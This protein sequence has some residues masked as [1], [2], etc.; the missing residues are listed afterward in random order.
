VLATFGV[1]RDATQFDSSIYSGSESLVKQGEGTLVLSAAN[2]HSG[3][4]VV[5]QGT[6]VVRNPAALGSGVVEVRSGAKLVLDGGGST[7]FEVSN[8]VLQPGGMIDV[9]TS[10]LSIQSG[11]TQASLVAAIDEAQGADGSW[12]GQSGIG[13]SVVK[14]MVASGTTRTLGWVGWVTNNDSSCIVG[15]AAPGDT[16][17][18]GQ[19]DIIDVANM[20]DGYSS[21]PE[22][23]AT[24]GVG[25]FN[26]D[27]TADV[28]DI[29]TYVQVGLYDTGSYLPED[30]PAAP[31]NLNVTA[32]STS[33]VS[34]AWETADSPRGFEIEQSSDGVSGWRAA[35]D[36]Y[37]L[38]TI[39]SASGTTTSVTIGG[40]SAGQSAFFRVRSYNDSPSW[41]WDDRYRSADTPAASGTTL[42]SPSSVF[43][44]GFSPVTD[45]NWIITVNGD[46]SV[47]ASIFFNFQNVQ[48]Q[49]GR[50][51][52]VRQVK[53]TRTIQ[54]PDSVS[55]VSATATLEW[56]VRDRLRLNGIERVRASGYDP[57]SPTRAMTFDL[58][59][60]DGD[61]WG[62]Y[63]FLTVNG[64]P[65]DP[66]PTP[67][68]GPNPGSWPGT[69]PRPQ[70]DPGNTGVPCNSGCPINNDRTSNNVNLP[71]GLLSHRDGTTLAS[72]AAG[73]GS[74][75]SLEWTN[76]AAAN[77]NQPFGN[78]WIAPGLPQ[79]Q[80]L[81]SDTAGPTWLAIPFSGSDT[82][83]FVR[84]AAN[85]SVYTPAFGGGSSDS[86]AKVGSKFEFR[87]VTGDTL[88]FNDFSS[89]TAGARGQFVEQSDAFGNRLA[90]TPAADGAM[91]KLESFSAGRT[92][93]TESQAYTVIPATQP[94]AGKVSQVDVRRAD[95]TTVRSTQYAYYTTGSSFGAAGDLKSITVLDGT[96]RLIDVKSYRYAVTT[97]AGNV[98]SRLQGVFDGDGWRRLTQAGL[99]IE[100]ASNGLV[101][102]YARDWYAFDGLGRVG[103][104]DIQGAGCSACTAGIGTYTYT[105]ENNPYSIDRGFNDWQT[106]TTETRPDGTQSITYSNLSGQTM[107]AVIR[108]SDAGVTKQYGTY[109]R[110]DAR[111]L[112]IWRASPE[113]VVLPSNLADIEPYRDLVNQSNGNCQYISDSSGMIEVT[114]YFQS[115]TATATVAN[116]ADRFVSST[117][118]MRGEKGTPITQ[119]AFTY[120]V[121]SAGVRTATTVAARTTYPTATTG[122]GQTTRYLYTWVP[123]TTQLNSMTEYL[124]VVTAEQNG[125][126]GASTEVTRSYDAAGR[127]IWS[128]DADGYLNYTSYDPETGA[129]KTSIKDVSTSRTGDFQNLPTGWAT[130]AGGGLHLVSTFDVDRLGRTIKA[131]DPAGNVTYTVYDDVNHST[132]TYVGW[133]A[134]TLT[135][136]GPIQVSRRDLSGT[137]TESLTYSAT[138]AVDAQGRP[139]GTEPITNLQWLTRSLMNAAGQVIA[140]DRYTNLIGLAYS[141]A[142]T[143]SGMATL[144]FEGVNY[145][146][147]RYAYNNQGQVDRVQNP[148]GTITISAYDGLARLT[149]TW[150]GT[151]DSTTNGFK[152][153]PSNASSSSNM[154]KVRAYEYDNGHVGNGNLTAA[155]EFPGGTDSPRVTQNS[156]DWRNRPVAT[157]TAAS[158][159]LATED[160]SVN[161]PLSVADYD[162]LGRVT[163]RSIYDGDG[164]ALGDT[165][166]DGVP[167]KPA[168]ALLRRS[169]VSVYDSQDRVYRTQE[170]FIDQTTGAVGAQSLTTNL[171]YDRRGNVAAVYAPNTPVSQSRYDG[172]GRLTGSFTLGNAPSATWASATS[173]AASLIL[174][175]IEYTYDAA[176]NVILTTDRERFHDASTTAFGGLGTP[177]TGIIARVSYAASYFDAANRLSAT[178]NVGTAG[179]IAY[180]RPATALAR[181]NTALVTSYTYDAAGRVQNVIDPKGIVARTLYDALGRTTTTIA[182]FTDGA[183]GSQTDVTTRFTFDAAGRL[184]SRTAVQPAGTPS[185]VTGYV[186]GI[187]PATGSTIASNDI[188]A[189]T[190]YPD[191][192]TG[193]ASTSERDTYTSNAL[194]ERTSLTDRA[195]TTHRYAYNVA[196]RLTT[197]TVT[198]AGSGVDAAI[199]RIRRVYDPLGRILKATSVKTATGEGN[200]S[201]Q[202]VLGYNGFGQAGTEWQEH[203]GV[204]GV[205]TP[206]VIYAYSQGSGGNHSR[207][208]QV[209]YPSGYQ[210]NYAYSGI[211]SAV[212]RPTSLSG[213]RANS[214]ASATFEAFKYLGAGTVVERS[215]PEVNVTLSMLNLSG[216]TAG[217]AGDKYTGLD[218]FGRVVDQRWTQGT[219]ATSPVVDRLTYTYDRNSN[220]LTRS[221]ALAAAFSETYGYDALNQLQSF[222]RGPESLPTTTQQWQPDALGN[223]LSVTTNRITQSSTPNAQ[224]EL[225]QVGSASPRYSSTGNLTTDAQGRTLVYDAWN[226][227]VSVKNSVGTEVARY[228]YDGLNRRITERVGTVA[229]PSAA[230]A[231]VRDLYY[232]QDWQV[233]EE[234]V[235]TSTGTIPT[236][237]DTRFIWSPVYVDAMIARDRNADGNAATGTGG[238]EQR[239]YA[240]QDANWNTTAIV[241]ATGVS[242]VAAG[243]VI[244]RFI[245]MPYGES[246]TLTATWGTPAAGST[247]ATP[248]SHLFQGLKVTDVTGLAYVRHRDYSP[249][250][251][252]FIELDPI[253]FAAG[254]NNWYRFVGN[255]PTGRTDP[256]GLCEID[257]Q[258]MGIPVT[259][260]LPIP[261]APKPVSPALDIPLPGKWSS[262]SINTIAGGSQSENFVIV[263]REAKQFIN[264]TLID[265]AVTAATAG[266][267]FGHVSKCGP[268]NRLGS[269]RRAGDNIWESAGGLRYAGVDRDGL[270]RVQHV[271]RHAETAGPTFTVFN[272]GRNNILA[273][274]DEAWRMRG[275]P[276]VN[277]PG[278]FVV[279]M[280]R[281]V[282]TAGENAVKIIVR[283]GTNE[284]ITAYP[285]FVP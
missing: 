96:G 13:S 71:T 157:K 219:A 278:A 126:A 23:A 104:H 211:D 92:V 128:R 79:L 85:S 217:D 245:Y 144:G 76:S 116:G 81:A 177:T 138:P 225:T 265:T 19:V 30:P 145:L 218:R 189:E 43:P 276:L 108:T 149:G 33:D 91:T 117:A 37:N 282:G 267:P 3:G 66:N 166:G 233:L 45:N 73:I 28:L 44:A 60:I 168:A 195:G 186:Y 95:N 183:A 64:S 244:N 188:L 40:F 254:D 129:V 182:N 198:A 107:L 165:N 51:D 193:V 152:W 62:G 214:T 115:T 32:L 161:R 269:L 155:T 63:V 109:T 172:A 255:S 268:A 31:T 279:R 232:S 124:P 181:S 80:Q 162:N 151:N 235:R 1:A 5:E 230:S 143:S 237:A 207:L 136:T 194:G 93:A 158:S 140:V 89:A 280:G 146:R 228:E 16:N 275:S 174:E 102:P 127:E 22:A 121:Q 248:W 118:V 57:I 133:I 94:N 69:G 247:P 135:P 196:G 26:R 210:V 100:T 74:D 111:G 160:S 180:V 212:S 263:K 21:Y 99:N 284:I 84:S 167:D 10:Q 75:A 119:E 11:F 243:N 216:T 27:G 202:V 97:V 120:Y 150:V 201:N 277:D 220:R 270:N 242:G 184:D 112:P 205:G 238:L 222:A 256:S 49:P 59:D 252:R 273:L 8:L 39:S 274:V 271:L 148:A 35:T 65:S 226:R 208:T 9:G 246:N 56:G 88:T 61:S 178:A 190:R 250:L 7:R 34:L 48:G 110:Y 153:T 87:T 179:G 4:T 223:W 259:T 229:F 139:T 54:I 137:Y 131:T 199:L 25:D 134:S 147:T 53:E 101:K 261:P 240:L 114:S 281:T 47:S 103:Q 6:L 251:G 187:S 224:N 221:N 141:T 67:D 98:V 163:G 283:P 257:D 159:S 83:V 264:D 55:L 260:W 78:G 12:N 266:V 113:A 209:T 203:A 90:A 77:G 204:A 258:F 123:G 164:V 52:S 130:P 86:I 132:R 46:S 50:G 38:Q 236:T 234:R 272:V 14:A 285:V 36:A 253:G 241:A 249:T 200:V 239:V 192:V 176:S 20:S 105:Y 170:L 171:F 173:L 262:G 2:T 175:Q 18:D 154:V 122:G 197:D 17:L 68:P 82:R 15:F 58:I 106:K 215:R 156:Y 24:W 191:P 185:Q 29:A 125:P 169:Q 42:L 213:Q 227:L 72:S 206:F 142:V 70:Q 231:A 41:W